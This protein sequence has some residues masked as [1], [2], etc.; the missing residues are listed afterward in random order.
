MFWCSV[1]SKRST[2]VIFT[3]WAWVRDAISFLAIKAAQQPKCL[4][5]QSL[6]QWQLSRLAAICRLIFAY[7]FSLICLS[8]NSI[9]SPSGYLIICLLVC[10]FIW[11]FVCLFL[12]FCLFVYH[13]NP[14]F[15]FVCLVFLYSFIHSF[16]H[17]FLS[18]FHS[19]LFSLFEPKQSVYFFITWYNLS[20]NF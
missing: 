3:E 19:F 17:S 4:N 10:R 13:V 12:S 14:S 2:Y 5:I 6:N 15:L 7:L 18:F 11:S 20:L 16:I 9:I 8:A 1:L